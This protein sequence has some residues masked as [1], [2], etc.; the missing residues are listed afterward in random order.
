MHL[1]LTVVTQCE[2]VSVRQA[3]WNRDFDNI[4]LADQSAAST[5]VTSLSDSLS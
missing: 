2:G 1:F 5:M 3:L 4:N